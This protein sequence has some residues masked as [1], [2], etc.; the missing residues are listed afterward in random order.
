MNGYDDVHKISK[1]QRR[2]RK[3]V[4]GGEWF[5]ISRR[6]RQKRTS[7]CKGWFLSTRY[8]L[9]SAMCHACLPVVFTSLLL[10][11]GWVQW[12]DCGCS[13][14]VMWQDASAGDSSDGGIGSGRKTPFRATEAWWWQ[15]DGGGG[16]K[17]PLTCISGN[18][19]F[20][21]RQRWMVVVG[22]EGAPSQMSPRAAVLVIVPLLSIL[23]S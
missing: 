11:R 16:K 1:I 14:V 17:T 9:E 2:R 21:N 19:G 12:A 10:L 15:R 22:V 3:R 7:I 5:E 20:T 23:L 6:N 4:E 18:R 13:D 8:A